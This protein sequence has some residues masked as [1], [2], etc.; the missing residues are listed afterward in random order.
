[1]TEPLNTARASNP[2]YD[3]KVMDQAHIDTEYFTDGLSRDVWED[4]YRFGNEAHLEESQA[5]TALGVCAKDPDHAQASFW[6][7]Q[8][9]LFLPAGRIHA[10]AGTGKHVTLVNCFVN[11]TIEDSMPA[12]LQANSFAGLTMQQGGGMGTDFSTIR[13]SGAILKRLGEGAVASGPLPFMDMWDAM[14]RTIMSAGSRRGAMMATLCDTHPDLPKFIVAKQTPGHLT[15]FNM[16]ILVSDALMEAIKEDEEWLLYFHEPPVKRPEGLEEYDFVDEET[17]LMQY[18]YSIWKARDLWKM[19]TKNTYEYSEP[20]V[21]FIDRI[22]TLNNLHYCEEIRCTNPCGEQPLPPHG[23]CNLGHVNLA[24]MVMRPFQPSAEFNFDLLRWVVEI[25]VRFLD[26]V[27]DVT[28]YPLLEQA[29]EQRQKRRQ[30]LGF[31]GLAD[32]LA[33]LGL[34]Y[35]TVYAADMAERITKVMAETAYFTSVELARERGAFPLFDAAQYLASNTFAG[36]MLR[37]DLK[38]DIR[39]YGIRNSLLLTIAPTGTVSVVYGNPGSGVEPFFAHYTKRKVLQADDKWKEY[40]EW[41]YSARV[42]A[43]VNGGGDPAQYQ[44]PNYMVSSKDLTI[45]EHILIQSRVQRWIDA[46]VSK[47]TNMPKE[48][49][50]DAFVQVYDL[51]Y[52]TG[53]KGCTTYRPSDVRGSVL[54]DGSDVTNASTSTDLGARRITAR[55]AALHGITYQIKWPSRKS[56]IYFILN[57]LPDGTPFESFI[58]SKDGRDQEWTTSLTLMITGVFRKGG[59]IAFVAEELQQI[60]SMHDG[61]WINKKYY[62]SLPAYIGHLIEQHL[63]DPLTSNGI[64][65]H[66][67]IHVEGVKG[68]ICTECNAPAVIMQEGCSKCQNYGHSNCG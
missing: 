34:R 17:G 3:P 62:G 65:T 54:S 2:F 27:I 29:E 68:D 16:S 36:S 4:K 31:T 12:I 39:K 41:S 55:P 32:A 60:Q 52:N 42:Y 5:R 66:D 28:G 6:A 11:A 1:M 61:A 64:V 47:T 57:S 15:N 51:A 46:S 30:G 24:R 9:G 26:N 38:A 19:I 44:L 48:T 14:C 8:A 67:D 59:N 63:K 33:Q 35:G 21:I 10:G 50:Y 13:P 53:C 18:V 43:H 45:S 49:S 40:T 20:G 23:A 56:A 7:M 58:T 37:D 22:N 25:A